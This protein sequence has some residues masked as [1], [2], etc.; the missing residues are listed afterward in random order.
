[1]FPIPLPELNP[2]AL[3][4]GPIAIRWYSLAYITG[5]LFGLFCLKK[6]NEKDKFLSAEAYD[7]WLVWMVLSIL[8]GGR[9]GYVFFYNAPYFFAHPL[10]ILAFW[11]GGMSFHGGLIGSIL[12]MWLFSKKYK[13]DFFQLTDVLA[14][15]TPVRL[16]FGRLANFV[17]MELYGR[18]TGSDYGIIF[19]GAGDFPRHPSQLYEAFLEGILLFIILF[20][21]QRFT[22]VS[23]THGI[24]RG[25]FLTF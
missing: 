6:A 10:E 11:H 3:S 4:L 20:S 18:I 12:G 21:L 7:N 5:I 19:P 9:F 23:R 2:I 13:I 15:A 16:F 24:L 14:V 17:N 25:V 8:L 22:K 1:M